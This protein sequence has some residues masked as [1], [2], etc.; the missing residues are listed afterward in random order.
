METWKDLYFSMDFMDCIEVNN[1]LFSKKID[2]KILS[3]AM[4]KPDN[5]GNPF[6][7]VGASKVVVLEKDFEKGLKIIAENGFKSDITFSDENNIDYSVP[8][9]KQ[10]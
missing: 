6:Q 1:L 8:F 7:P 2:S 10:S 9:P 5:Q 4:V 3:F